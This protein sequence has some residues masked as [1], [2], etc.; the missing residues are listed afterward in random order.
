MLI[1]GFDETIYFKEKSLGPLIPV[2]ADIELLVSVVKLT[3]ANLTHLYNS[4]T[5]E[6]AEMTTKCSLGSQYM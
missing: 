1:T 6:L 2:C 5:T 4:R 3:G